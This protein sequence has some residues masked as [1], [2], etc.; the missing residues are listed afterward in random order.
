MIVPRPK[1]RLYTPTLPLRENGRE[2]AGLSGQETPTLIP[3]RPGTPRPRVRT[4]AVLSSCSYAATRDGTCLTQRQT[5]AARSGSTA[6]AVS[7]RFYLS[8]RRDLPL[9]CLP[10]IDGAST[11]AGRAAFRA[12]L[13]RDD[14][15]GTFDRRD[16]RDRPS[17]L[18][19]AASAHSRRH[20]PHRAKS[21]HPA[22][23]HPLRLDARPLEACRRPHARRG[24][25]V[26]RV[27]RPAHPPLFRA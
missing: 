2:G 14:L 5:S 15:L 3:R 20:K 1:W 24:Q 27:P 26:P 11:H 10:E 19:V 22:L 23:Q 4:R 21:P 9:T 8:P 16:A 13:D 6:L 17:S 25:A 7:V 18:T 12:S